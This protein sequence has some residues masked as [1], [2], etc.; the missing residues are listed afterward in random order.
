[1]LA[2]Y[3]YCRVDSIGIT[4]GQIDAYND[5][6]CTYTVHILAKEDSKCAYDLDR[7]VH[8][9]ERLVLPIKQ[10][11]V[12][13]EG[14]LIQLSAFGHFYSDNHLN[15]IILARIDRVNHSNISDYLY[16]EILEASDPTNVGE[17][18]EGWAWWCFEPVTKN[19]MQLNHAFI[20]L[21]D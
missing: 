13:K 2:M 15:S 21:F 7:K 18:I 8:V 16:G 11:Y 9:D 3:T 12:P 20:S 17:D 14:D 10:P 4:C 6:D 5:A 19:E 1:M